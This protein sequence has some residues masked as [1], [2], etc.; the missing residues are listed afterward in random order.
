MFLRTSAQVLTLLLAVGWGSPTQ[1]QMWP[2]STC[3]AAV[4]AKLM[5]EKFRDGALRT[6]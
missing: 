4:V 1:A 5:M 3:Y 2:S 6:N